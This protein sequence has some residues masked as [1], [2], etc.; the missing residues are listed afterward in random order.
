MSGVQGGMR[1]SE[2]FD[3]PL[4][5]DVRTAARVLGLCPATVYRRLREQDFP[6]PVLRPGRQYR[7]PTAGLLRALGI[8]EVPV[9][10]DDLRRGAQ[11]AA[12]RDAD[13]EG[14]G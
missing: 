14:R 6:C 13:P 5:I 11:Y 1:F 8:E 2:V 9:H 3:L 4:T 12:A 7:I 10:A